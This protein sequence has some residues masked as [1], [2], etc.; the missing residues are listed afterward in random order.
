MNRPSRFVLRPF[1]LICAALT[2]GG[3]GGDGGNGG[4]GGGGDGGGAFN[5]GIGGRLYFDAPA[6]Y[7]EFNPADG[8]STIVLAGES[9]AGTTPSMDASEFVTILDDGSGTDEVVIFQRDGTVSTRIDVGGSLTGY[10]RLS[11]DGSFVALSRGFGEDLI[12]FDR[13][14]VIVRDFSGT[15]GTEGFGSYE[16]MPDGRLAFIHDESLFLA[17]QSLDVGS[18]VRSFP[19]EAP[20]GLAASADGSRLAL[21]LLRPGSASSRD[22]WL[23][24][25]DGGD[26]RRLA[27]AQVTV[28][29]PAWSPD[30][31]SIALVKGIAV[32]A[33]GGGCPELWVVPSDASSLDLSASDPSPAFRVQERK[34]GGQNGVCVF[35]PPEWRN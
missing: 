28:G 18:P 23:L 31:A 15:L 11:P 20:S 7:I 3:C 25:P 27:T 8:S 13:N 22:V 10:P 35:S 26:L 16:W 19:G 32:G 4:G 33:G 14:G 5:H 34:N 17:G 12:V 21:S 9:G 24:D 30:G 2:L 29:E 6:D 1:L